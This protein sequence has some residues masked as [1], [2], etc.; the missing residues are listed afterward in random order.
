LLPRRVRAW[1]VDLRTDLADAAMLLRCCLSDEPVAR[2]RIERVIHV[3]RGRR[4]RSPRW[5]LRIV[6]AL[7]LSLFARQALAQ[8]GTPITPDQMYRSETG[9]GVRLAPGLIA[10]PQA[11]ALIEYDSNVYNVEIA[12]KSDFVAYFE[13]KLRVATDLPRHSLELNARAAVRRYFKLGAENSEEYEIAG[14]GRL[15]LADRTE[16]VPELGLSRRIEM[17]GTAGDEFLTDSPVRYRETRA[18]LG[19]YRTGGTLDLAVEGQIRTNVYKDAQLDGQTISLDYRDVTFRMARVRPSLRL[20][21]RSR[22]FGELAYNEVDY[23]Q[24]RPVS[25]DSHGLAGLLGIRFQLTSLIDAEAAAGL[26]RQTFDDPAFKTVTGVNYRVRATWTPTPYWRVS[27]NARRDID[28][29]PRT[30]TPAIVRSSFDLRA[31]RALNER[32]KVAL[33]VGYVEENYQEISRTDKHVGIRAEANYR[34]AENFGVFLAGGYRKQGGGRNG[35]DFDGV[36][37]SLGMR[38]VL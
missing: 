38:A 32:T 36:S 6:A 10:E 25:R 16:V 2:E 37:V 1:I 18:A 23:R 34:L 3:G 14:K 8:P 31:E 15:E 30:D 12:R 33:A 21:D 22:V 19:I 27:A 29:G 20:S 7:V 26:I 5:L 35:R 4:S 24:A 13:P 17:R 11:T 9:K 28:A